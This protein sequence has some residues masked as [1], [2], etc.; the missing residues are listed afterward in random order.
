MFQKYSE[1]WFNSHYFRG[2]F[3]NPASFHIFFEFDIDFV[4][5]LQMLLD[6]FVLFKNIY[7]FLSEFHIVF[8]NFSFDAFYKLIKFFVKI[9][10]DNILSH[11]CD[12]KLVI[13]F[14]ISSFNFTSFF[15]ISFFYEL[16]SQIKM[17]FFLDFNLFCYRFFT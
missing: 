8:I 10:D 12:D 17:G 16:S 15:S 5:F 13:F 6:L 3:Y 4:S 7:F 9:R 1:I 14:L 2:N 11:K